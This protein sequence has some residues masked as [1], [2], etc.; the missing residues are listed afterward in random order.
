MSELHK[1]SWRKGSAK[2]VFPYLAKRFGLVDFFETGVGFG[3]TLIFMQP[4]FEQ[5]YSIEL[6]D[7]NYGLAAELFRYTPN[8]HL[9]HGDSGIILP[10]LLR[11]APQRP[12][13]FW[14][15]AHGVPGSEDGP[16]AAEIAAV[17][18]TSPDSLIAIDD[19]GQGTH[20]GED[21]HGIDLKG[22]VKD[23][24]FGRVMFLHRGH[25]DIP[26]LD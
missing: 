3:D 7:W 25:Y 6:M 2:V 4:V 24:R 14:L 1:P 26:N 19:V 15:D 16:L 5:C 18:E 13:L 8:V 17:Q 21:L 22:W 9:F 20:H 11:S 23:Y 12:S 10:E